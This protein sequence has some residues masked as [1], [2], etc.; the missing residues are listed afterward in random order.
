MDYGIL[1]LIS[2]ILCFALIFISKNAFI[3]ITVGI[4]S[5]LLLV[6]V[7]QGKFV[8]FSSI[9]DV[10]SSIST[11]QTVL[12][13]LI[14]GAIIKSTERSKG[15]S[16]LM[17]YLQSKKLNIKSKVMVQ[18]FTMLIGI[19]MFVDMTS[20]IAIT[21]L[22]GKPLY[23]EAQISR[24]KLALITNS[25]A[26]PIA[27]IIP[28]GGAAALMTGLISQ[29]D[30][31][32]GD[33]FSYVIA[34]V[35]LQFYTI[36]L[37]VFLA[38]SVILKLEIGPIKKYA[39]KDE[40]DEKKATN[41]NG[42]ARNMV[43]PI[44]LL[45]SFILAI[46]LITGKG[47]ILAGDGATAVFF[48][49]I[50]T[51]AVIL[52]FYSAQKICSIKECLGWFFEGVKS[53]FLVTLLLAIALVFSELLSRIGTAEYL[54]GI[55]DVISPGLLPAIALILSAIIA[56]ST[57]TSGGTVAIVTGLILPMAVM[58]DVNISLVLGAIVSG[59]V[60][61]D[62]NSIISDSVILT[63]SVTGVNA[64]T[65]VKTQL[66]YTLVA[67]GIS[68]ILFTIIGMMGV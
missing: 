39:F 59:S 42:R 14:V 7:R 28:F 55:F 56:F 51:L 54:V 25:T 27:W 38:I 52:I 3:A 37:L 24:E 60:F 57:G 48:G 31:I 32:T 67:L 33:A 46:M 63:T 16:G 6:I 20:S 45:V 8:L 36:S 21:A 22:V 12:F 9:A 29:I 44:I 35:P 15:V 11:L 68:L 64:V 4:A 2:I 13:I 41:S 19:V 1:S 43:V 61:G 18:L 40:K 66:P 58:S 34:A 62:Q 65:H 30:G 5:S 26:S 53:M 17:S 47:N 23:K 50:L 49:G 10:F